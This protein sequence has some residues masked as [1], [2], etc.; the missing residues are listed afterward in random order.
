[1]SGRR[2][3]LAPFAAALGLYFGALPIA[4]VQAADLTVDVDNLRNSLGRVFIT[5]FNDRAA[6]LDATRTFADTSVASVRGRVT[7]TFKELPPGR[8]AVV[9]F[10]DENNNGRFDQ[11]F[12]G[13]PLEGYAF[14]QNV[15]PFLSAPR[16]DAAAVE[17]GGEDVETAIH[18]VY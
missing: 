3:G 11:N 17:L 9:T 8:Y 14:S 6:W 5:V 1:V 2:P 15:R 16:F 4:A 7:V 12:L 13:L 10:H 18:M